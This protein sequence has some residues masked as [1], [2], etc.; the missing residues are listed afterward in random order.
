MYCKFCGGQIDRKTMRCM[1]CGSPVGP[2]EGGVGF[3]DLAGGKPK[4][5]RQDP[6]PP[7]EG[8][9]E[10]ILRQIAFR[11]GRLGKR[12]P[13]LTMIAAGILIFAILQSAF[14]ICLL[15]GQKRA[16][17]TLDDISGKLGNGSPAIEETS[18]ASTD[19]LKSPDL[20]PGYSM[21]VFPEPLNVKKEQDGTISADLFS[22][23][24]KGGELDIL[25]EKWENRGDGSDYY[26]ADPAQVSFEM[27]EG[28]EGLYILRIKESA[29]QV[30]GNYRWTIKWSGWGEN[31]Y[32]VSTM[33]L[34]GEIDI[35]QDIET[36]Q[37]GGEPE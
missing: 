21:T 28:S 8:K 34:S 9:S 33:T 24:V 6:L 36:A 2:L 29:A 11:S 14:L 12:I 10:E 17:E 25:W 23:E 1:D 35:P 18:E 20:Y 37:G 5:E 4:E 3:W 30:A 15:T 13:A 7:R 31:G 22:L 27:K 16:G 26:E 32:T 19:P